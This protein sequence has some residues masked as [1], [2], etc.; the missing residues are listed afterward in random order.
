MASERCASAI[1]P[2][3]RT[4]RLLP[5]PP[6]SMRHTLRLGSSDKRSASAQPAVPAP[7]TTKSNPSPRSVI[8]RKPR[9]LPR[10][11]SLTDRTPG[12]ASALAGGRAVLRRRAGRLH[13][14]HVLG[15]PFGERLVVDPAACEQPLAVHFYHLVF[16]V[17]EEVDRA[18]SVGSAGHVRP[19][20]DAMRLVAVDLDHHVVDDVPADG[21]LLAWRSLRARFLGT[22]APGGNE[23]R[24]GLASLDLAAAVVEDAVGRE[25]AGIALR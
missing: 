18:A 5:L 24:D 7:T 3:T 11:G 12:L 15:G 8:G 22:L 17:T 20:R 13:G 16:V 25:R 2:G 4:T 14:I 23:R 21:R 1:A 19:V 6:A 10:P 9:G